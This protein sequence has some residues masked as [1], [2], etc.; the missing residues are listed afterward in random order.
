MESHFPCLISSLVSSVVDPC[1]PYILPHLL[2]PTTLLIDRFALA[3]FHFCRFRTNEL[4]E[5]LYNRP[6]FPVFSPSENLPQAL[7]S[8]FRSLDEKR[9]KSVQAWAS[10]LSTRD[11]HKGFPFLPFI[12]ILMIS[13]FVLLN[14]KNCHFMSL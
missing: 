8:W 12:L 3:L 7:F 10:I 9:M 5:S 1:F 2:C 11:L 6:D 14:V 4:F 13:P